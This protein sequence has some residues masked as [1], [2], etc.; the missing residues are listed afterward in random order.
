MLS[1]WST[2]AH[3]TYCRLLIVVVFCLRH[4]LRPRNSWPLRPFGAH[5]IFS[6]IC[7]CICYSLCHFSF[8]T[9][10]FWN[11]EFSVHSEVHKV[12]TRSISVIWM[13]A[14]LRHCNV[15]ACNREILIFKVGKV[16]D[17]D[18]NRVDSQCCLECFQPMVVCF[19]KHYVPWVPNALPQG[20]I[21]P[22]VSHF[23]VLT[24]LPEHQTCNIRPWFFYSQLCLTWSQP[25]RRSI[26]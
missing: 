6:C 11:A 10:P 25:K 21:V 20:D 12:V 15:I 13:L 24:L 9:G 7:I 2:A 8:K 22:M 3:I 18:P 23:I 16:L 1:K 19:L 26:T 17:D 14:V 5:E 4:K